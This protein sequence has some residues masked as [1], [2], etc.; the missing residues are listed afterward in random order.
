[1]YKL[2]YYPRNAS[3]APHLILKELGVEFE[4][5]LVDRRSEAQKAAEYLE[6]NPTGRIPTLVDGGSALFESAA[7]ALYLC[8]K[9][10]EAE[11]LPQAN[12]TE[13]ALCYQWLFYLTSTLQPELMIYFYPEKHTTNNNSTPSIVEAQE[14]RITDMYGILNDQIGD[15][16]YLV[17]NK[18]SICDYFLFMLC[19][20]GSGF[21][22]PPIA[23]PNL[24]RCLRNL[25]SKE[26]FQAVCTTEGTKLDIYK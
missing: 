10:P 19:H 7:I 12:S 15:R 16:E 11:L 21:K 17:G 23:F 8:E 20:W 14:Q 22:T 18:I 9:H 5:V 6:L 1:M 13:R 25:A 24:A 3:W 2:F 4:L 26:A